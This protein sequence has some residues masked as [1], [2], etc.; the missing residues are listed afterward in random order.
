MHYNHKTGATTRLTKEAY[1]SMQPVSFGGDVVFQSWIGDDWEVVFIDAEDGR[2]ILT[3][4]DVHDIAPS[5]TKEFIMWQSFE[6]G[7]WVAKVYDR[8]TKE[9]QTVKG[10]EGGVVANPR[11]IMVFDNK[12]G[13]GDVETVGYDP[14]RGEVVPLAVTPVSIPERIP[15][16]EEKQEEKALVQPTTGIR[17]ETKS[18][19]STGNGDDE[20]PET[21]AVATTTVD[22]SSESLSTIVPNATVDIPDLVIPAFSISTSTTTSI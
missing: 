10:I 20:E 21:P 12:K 1:N 22:I 4:N 15:E 17:I 11:M 19:T 2:E 6:E 3:D 16:P 18:A 8:K 7:A 14:V 5:I 13:N 9:V